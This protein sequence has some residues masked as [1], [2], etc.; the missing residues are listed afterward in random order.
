MVENVLELCIHAV[1]VLDS[2]DLGITYP[3]VLQLVFSLVECLTQTSHAPPNQGIV[4]GSSVTSVDAASLEGVSG[5]VILADSVKS[6]GVVADPKVNRVIEARLNGAEAMLKRAM[7]LC[8]RK[9]GTS[10]EAYLKVFG[11]PKSSL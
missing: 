1:N 11:D 3:P 6:E 7:L 4:D 2:S 10:G 9:E 8:K 5:S